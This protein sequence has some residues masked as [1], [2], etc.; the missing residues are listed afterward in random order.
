MEKDEIRR[1][2]LKRM[3]VTRK[4][5]KR[6]VANAG[7]MPELRV[8]GSSCWWLCVGLWAVPLNFD[9]LD[10]PVSCYADLA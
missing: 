1:E 2:A 8:V 9:N 6:I 7:H 5:N 3:H 4:H 10:Q